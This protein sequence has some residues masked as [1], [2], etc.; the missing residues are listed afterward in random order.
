MVNSAGEDEGIG[1]PGTAPSSERAPRLRASRIRRAI[2]A[3]INRYRGRQFEYFVKAKLQKAGFTVSRVNEA[4][5]FTHGVDLLVRLRRS[6]CAAEGSESGSAPGASASLCAPHPAGAALAG[7][8][9][10]SDA[11]AHLLVPVQVKR[12]EDWKDLFGAL[13]ECR[14]ECTQ[15]PLCVAIHG[16]VPKG[17]R[18]PRITI[19]ISDQPARPLTMQIIGWNDLIARLKAL[20]SS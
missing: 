15:D 18:I 1:V 7:S 8:E 16:W 11:P 20:E 10:S 14:K 13:A 5:G 3:R 9:G 4:D 2:R 17:K 19:A 12:T 6:F